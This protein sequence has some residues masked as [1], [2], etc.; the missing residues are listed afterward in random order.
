LREGFAVT[1]PD[2]EPFLESSRSS[3]GM[4]RGVRHSANLSRTPAGWTRPAQRP[5]DSQ[6]RW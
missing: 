5:G 1:P 6:P 2:L 4:L 3:F